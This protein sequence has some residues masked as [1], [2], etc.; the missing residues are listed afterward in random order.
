MKIP[1]QQK[2][3][4]P[5]PLTR[6]QLLSKEELIILADRQ[7]RIIAAINKDNDRLRAINNELEQK[8][9]FVDEQF[10]TIKNKLFGKS[11][12]RSIVNKSS[13]TAAWKDKRKRIS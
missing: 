7:E 8:S 2:L 11:S 10:I 3:F 1:E 12:E 13:T 5:V 6:Y 9:L 4:E